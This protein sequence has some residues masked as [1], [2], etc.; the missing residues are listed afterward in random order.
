MR[1]SASA[2]SLPDQQRAKGT[3]TNSKWAQYDSAAPR[4]RR[5][6]RAVH[7]G[8][9]LSAAVLSTGRLRL[10]LAALLALLLAAHWDAAAVARA[11]SGVATAAGAP[12]PGPLAEIA[13]RVQ[14]LLHQARE[15]AAPLLGMQSKEQAAA[16]AAAK[17]CH[18]LFGPALDRLQGQVA[19]AAAA[20]A[21]QQEPLGAGQQ[22]RA[23]LV[24]GVSAAAGGTCRLYG[25]AHSQVAAVRSG[26][27][28]PAQAARAAAAAA[29]QHLHSQL[30]A[31][32]AAPLGQQVLAAVDRLPPL[33]SLMLLDLSLV[34]AA[35][36]A[37][38]AA[39]GL[40]H[41]TV[42]WCRGGGGRL[43]GSCVGSGPDLGGFPPCFP[44][45]NSS[46]QQC[47]LLHRS[48]PAAAGARPADAG[49]GDA[50][51]GLGA[52]PGA[53]A[54]PGVGGAAPGGGAAGRCGGVCG[55]A[56]GI[57][58]AAPAAGRRRRQRVSGAAAVPNPVPACGLHV[59]GL[60]CEVQ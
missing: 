25:E 30:A 59:R 18:Q 1:K 21:A 43:C 55:G 15:A 29:V 40:V 36:A 34:G 46:K 16:A 37:M 11:S 44:F 9:T 5:R 10:A 54:E 20:A 19:A 41:S 60:R 50:A 32:A 3:A 13:S 8:E 33:A 31:V 12:A 57:P 48:L 49:P 39:P 24:R 23:R 52:R 27:V 14:G 35:A 58:A 26:S 38:A 22:L 53:A 4:Q 7:A 28:S 2:Q 42:R 51:G 45:S 56:C 47:A 17:Q 6:L